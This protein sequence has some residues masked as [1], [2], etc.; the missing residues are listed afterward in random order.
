MDSHPDTLRERSDGWEWLLALL[1]GGNLVWTTLC[2]GG[3]RPETMLVTSLLTATAVVV[4]LLA[5][6]ARRRVV[7]GH[8]VGW[9]FTPFGVYAL[10]NVLWLTPVPWLGWHD[11]MFWA[12]A[13]GV[14]WVVLNGVRARSVQVA[15]LGCVG[16]LVVVAT[17]MACY[18]RFVRPE[19]LMLGRE[20]S[21]QFLSRSSGPFGIPNSLAAFYLLVLP[22][23]L[24]LVVRRGASL[25]QR[26]VFGTIALGAMYGLF[27]TV[28]RG[29][30]LALA[31]ALSLWPLVAGI[32]NW[33]R[34]VAAVGVISLLLLVLGGGLYAT[35]AGVRSRFDAMRA[36]SGEW[37][38][39]L[40]WRGA[41]QLF[42]DAPWTGTGAGS[43]NVL[44]E[45][46]RPENYQMEPRWA[47]ND[48]LNTLS[49]YGL[50]GF[51]LLFGV[52]AVLTV[53]GLSRKKLTERARSGAVHPIDSPWI[54][55]ALG[56]GLLAF[57]L[58]LVVDFHFKIPALGMLFA[59]SAALLVQRIWPRPVSPSPQARW[60]GVLAATIV[61]V[62]VVGWVY[63]HYRAEALRYGT[64]QALGKLWQYEPTDAVYRDTLVRARA[65]LARACTID[66]A[67]PQAWTDRAMAE[68]LW[69]HVVPE[70]SVEL[71]ATGE[72]Y[73][74]HALALTRVNAEFWVR[75]AVARD[76][77][78]DWTGA[79]EDMAEALRL[80]P[81]NA[82]VWFYQAHH[83]SLQTFTKSLALAA[84][85]YCLRLDPGNVPAQRLRH[86]LATSQ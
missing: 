80:A 27:L 66:P 19:W 59:L 73:A 54:S 47:H 61:S 29:G 28:S 81:A 2:L 67:N 50:V 38:R 16:G 51:G 37:T 13:Y 22:V 52:G 65:D 8:W 34:R 79:S 64:R 42:K 86:K 10:G 46:V 33:R 30:W 7:C 23:L 14:F 78:G 85:D 45:K 20:Q 3:Y 70:K 48:Y 9:L 71:G 26:I 56:I 5:M 53:C 60:M 18:Q 57:M 72:A 40:M 35:N 12:N 62:L 83:L 44:F 43:Y 68:S 24:G 41:W 55:S 63:P 25:A 21:E 58:Q 31:I 77:Q 11:W 1:L 82:Q 6:A 49:D 32:G 17:I 4:H 84:F 75:R 39:V 76:M 36:A 15:L 74:N 69:S